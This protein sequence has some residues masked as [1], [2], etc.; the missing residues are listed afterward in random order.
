M[1]R[2]SSTWLHIFLQA[3]SLAQ[4]GSNQLDYL[5][6]DHLHAGTCMHALLHWRRPSDLIFF[7]DFFVTMTPACMMLMH[8][9]TWLVATMK[10]VVQKFSSRASTSGACSWSS[11]VNNVH[12]LLHA[13][14]LKGCR[15]KGR[16]KK[17][18]SSIIDAIGLY[19]FPVSSS[20]LL[21]LLL[22]WCSNAELSLPTMS[23]AFRVNPS[24][25]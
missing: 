20:V 1:N 4:L 10:H 6:A 23:S 22:C 17:K 18:H 21:Q 13:R 19:Q 7:Q 8:T 12:G 9:Y 16:R 2:G 15:G 3:L 25:T 5:L 24:S 14:Y 11:P